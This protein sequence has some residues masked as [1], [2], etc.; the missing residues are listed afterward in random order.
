[1]QKKGSTILPPILDVNRAPLG[2]SNDAFSSR[3]QATYKCNKQQHL[4]LSFMLM[5]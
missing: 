2:Q 1:M 4:E 3:A 5:S